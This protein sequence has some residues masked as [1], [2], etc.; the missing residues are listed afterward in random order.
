MDYRYIIKTDTYN[1]KDRRR[2][3]NLRSD[4]P[5]TGLANPSV[6]KDATLSIVAQRTLFLNNACLCTVNVFCCG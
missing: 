4:G 3:N 5:G 6:N 2:A 1:N